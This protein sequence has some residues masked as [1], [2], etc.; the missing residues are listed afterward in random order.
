M[1]ITKKNFI[2]VAEILVHHSADDVM[3]GAFADYFASLNPNFNYSYFYSY[4]EE[5]REDMKDNI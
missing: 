5:L 4:I 1:S 3:V 2:A